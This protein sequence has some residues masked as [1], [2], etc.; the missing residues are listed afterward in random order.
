MLFL[1]AYLTR[2]RARGVINRVTISFT[3][4]SLIILILLLCSNSQMTVP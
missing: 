4:Y 2:E 1:D 3:F